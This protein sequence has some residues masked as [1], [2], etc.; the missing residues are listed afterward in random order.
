MSV[1]LLSMR[2]RLLLSLGLGAGV[3]TGASCIELAST[4][5]CFEMAEEADDDGIVVHA[6]YRPEAD[7]ECLH[8][9]A[10]AVSS[11][12]KQEWCGAELEAVA[13]GPVRNGDWCEY[14]VVFDEQPNPCAV[15]GRPFLVGAE[16]V[17]APVRQRGGW[18]AALGSVR[19]PEDPQLRA[20]LSAHWA[21]VAQ[22]EH[23]SIA[24]FARFGLQLLQL[25]APPRLL[26][27]CRE[28]M[29]D[30]TRHARAAFELA[31]RF[32]GQ[33]SLGPGS[34]PVA[35]ACADSDAVAILRDVVL[36]GCL[37]ETRAAAEA[38]EAARSCAEPTLRRALEAIA[39]DEERHAALAWSFVAWLLDARP[40]LASTFAALVDSVLEL[41]LVAPSGSV[42]APSWGLLSAE[43]RRRIDREV[44]REL[45]APLA[46]ALLARH[47][48]ADNSATQV[49]V[50]VC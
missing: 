50:R 7:G 16:S 26:T 46:A 4:D 29:V 47:Q 28:A 44:R 6:Q 43:A 40:E 48:R 15:I 27:A 13:C 19:L 34:L 31:A 21:E 45:V 41:P 33:G 38:R 5:S 24:A 1:E 12:A 23:A 14:V 8:E 36:E 18:S 25:G 32:G 35:D 2:R 9:N 39:V 20:A 10:S 11:S 42:D 49:H 22:A 3:V 30:E 37:G 17:C